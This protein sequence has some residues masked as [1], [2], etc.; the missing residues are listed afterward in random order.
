M[1]NFMGRTCDMVVDKRNM[2]MHSAFFNVLFRNDKHIE[3][4]QV[5]FNKN[6][7]IVLLEVDDNSLPEEYFSHYMDVVKKNM[8]F[9]HYELK[10]NYP[11]LPA[12]NAK[13]RY[14]IN[15]S[16]ESIVQ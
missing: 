2:V 5:Q 15:T 16:A 7:I 3:Q 11:F 14:V 10:V 13:H 9:D 6:E 12:E 1:A 4:F 8:Q